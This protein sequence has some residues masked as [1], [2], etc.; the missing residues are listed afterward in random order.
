METVQVAIVELFKFFAYTMWAMYEFFVVLGFLGLFFV[1]KNSSRNSTLQEKCDKIEVVIVSVASKS[2]KKSLF[3]CIDHTRRLF[4]NTAVTLV[5]DDNAE[6]LEEL[7]EL[8]TNNNININSNNNNVTTLVQESGNR[9][10]LHYT[11][12]SYHQNY[13]VN[14]IPILSSLINKGS[15]LLHEINE[16]LVLSSLLDRGSQLMQET[17]G[18]LSI[19]IVPKGY[20]L[21][22]I[23]KGRAMNYFIDTRVNADYWYVF[24]D[25]DNIIMDEKFLY[26]IPYYEAEGYVAC[27]PRVVPRKGKSKFTYV[28]DFIRWF[29]DLTIFRFFTGLL[30]RPMLGMHGEALTIKGSI[31]KKIGYANRTLTEDFR[32][33]AELVTRKEKTWQSETVISLKSA[34]NITDL[35]K[36]RG[37]WFKG[38]AT[39]LEFCPPLM[40]L[41]VSARLFIWVGGILGSWALLPMWFFWHDSLM[42][43]FIIGGAYPWIVFIY[44]ILK[45][46][47]PLYYIPLIPLYGIL[48]SIS[49]LFGLKQKKFVVIDKN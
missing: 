18:P 43:Y 42:F 44:G 48:E 46:K 40:K 22:L 25:D 13:Y 5:V 47:Q 20:R 16:S 34:N 33:A 7:I 29:D 8:Q 32:F 39:D 14:K 19:E 4:K 38:I 35:C 23:G 41:L 11:N 31:L 12:Y 15:Q 27:N 24:V 10:N 49:F 3:E 21:D 1:P 17:A 26:E 37:R 6:L 30:G 28:M 9:S 2:V 36:Q 45:T